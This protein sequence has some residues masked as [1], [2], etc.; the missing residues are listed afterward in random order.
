MFG[1]D[2]P[3]MRKI[4][5]VK[6][7]MDRR[8][9]PSVYQSMQ[10]KKKKNQKEDSNLFFKSLWV[11]ALMSLMVALFIS[12]GNHYFFQMSLSFSLLLFVLASALVAD[13][14]SVLLDIRDKNILSPR[15]VNKAT[16]SCAKLVHVSIYMF[17]VTA[18]TTVIP[19]VVGFF[20]HG[21]FFF[22]I[23]LAE[24]ILFDFFIVFLTALLYFLVLKFF[25]GEKLKDIINYVQI[26]LTLAIVIG[27]Q[28]VARMFDLVDL[29]HA[30]EPT[31]WQFFLPPVWYSAP[32]ELFLNGHWS[33]AYVVLSL[34]GLLVPIVA[35]ALYILCLPAFEKNLEKLAEQGGR[36]QVK[37]RPL[38]RFLAKILCAS[39]QEN[40]FYR[41][42]G[43][44]MAGE[45]DFKLKVY[46]MLGLSVIFP[47]I[48][49]FNVLRDA[50]LAQ[51]GEGKSYLFIYFSLIQLPSVVM[52]LQYSGKYKG[53]WI[54][55]T[56]PIANLAALFKGTLKACIIKLYVPIY[57]IISVIFLWIFGFRILPD[58]LVV[59]VASALY[60]V[61]CHKALTKKL[62]FSEAI[63]DSQQHASVGII[64]IFMLLI[65]VFIGVHFLFTLIPYGVYGYLLILLVVNVI[66]W[67]KAFPASWQALK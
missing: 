42:A 63:T 10:A 17:W 26:G 38:N 15:P 33:E 57:I 40:A 65:G 6:L 1:V 7:L 46:P 14:S 8:R 52:M 37:R 28:L 32:F 64:L 30:F 13:F 24:I 34:L 12:F 22:L 18:A 47:F 60:M 61:I 21:A 36:A 54:Y 51:V 59:L 25:D 2:Y 44:M 55:Q 3:I 23:F 31:L 20:T 56:A 43:R 62:P 4:L 53:A 45:R 41:F 67:K 50:S 11:Y 27:Y 5:Q 9:V 29:N 58:L 19:L 16:I 66:A 35:M 39:P 49:L 48:F